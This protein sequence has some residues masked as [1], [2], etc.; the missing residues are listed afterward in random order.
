MELASTTLDALPNLAGHWRSTLGTDEVVDTGLDH[1]E[2]VLD[3]AALRESGAEESS[4]ESN[5]DPRAALEEDGRKQEAD[6]E[7]DL[8]TGDDGHG[9]VIVLLDEAANS[10]R[11]GVGREGR[12]RARG[13]GRGKNL[14]RNDR[15]DHVGASV[16]RDVENRVDGVGEHGQRILGHEEPNEGH[17]C[18]ATLAMCSHQRSLSVPK[19]LRT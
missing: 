5:Q 4:V 8:E 9:H 6:P 17:G 13:C 14:G 10:V 11:Q 18:R 16:G 12:L 2:R 3:V 1:R 15:G 7:E 19:R